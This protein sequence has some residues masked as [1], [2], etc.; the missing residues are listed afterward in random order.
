VR[1]KPS[2]GLTFG[3][4]SE[5]GLGAMTDILKDGETWKLPDGTI[6]R[7]R[8]KRLGLVIARQ[9][10]TYRGAVC[11]ARNFHLE[12][13]VNR[14]TTHFPLGTDATE[15]AKK[16]DEIGS[17]LS[18]PTNT[19]EMARREYDP[20]GVAR[21][22]KFAT[23]KEVFD[24]HEKGVRTLG[25]SPATGKDYRYSLI[26]IIRRVEA[27]QRG[28]APVQQPGK[29]LDMTP[30]L[31]LPTTVLT[32]KQLL[33]FKGAM[34]PKVA[35]IDGVLIEPDEEEILTA[36]ISCDSFMRQAR[37]IFSEDARRYYRHL[38]IPLPDLA[39]WLEV[40]M[41]GARKYFELP[42]AD[43][44]RAIFQDLG[45]LREA[46]A[47]A[48]RAFMLCIHLGLRKGEA[49]AARWEWIEDG[50]PL[51]KLREDGQFRPKHGHGRKVEFERW[52]LDELRG[53]IA[54]LD[55]ILEGNET[56]RGE[57]VFSRL[58]DYLRL[59]GITATKPTHELRKLWFS[60]TAKAKGMLAAQQQGGHSD[61]K[62][63][64]QCYAD[65]MMPDEL[66]RFWKGAA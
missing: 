13:M 60:Y 18:I 54:S 53:G 24:A 46:D 36:Q 16:A 49:A 10:Y 61:P 44:V 7:R 30:W 41:F 21:K 39:E 20:R 37:A 34:I 12:V 63:T 35:R 51:M 27:S 9:R 33:D 52:V 31:S 11:F 50:G 25:I 28:K 26:H 1:I 8:T 62:V 4:K 64:S 43:V 2:T 5:R 45:T 47:N 55:T 58:N 6:V 29:R 66:L 23:L 3:K 65:N 14:V 48:W 38:R 15:A 40:P 57:R 59:H 42:G 19:L 56:E 17:F 32:A 22:E